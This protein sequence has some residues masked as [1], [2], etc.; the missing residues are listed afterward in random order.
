VRIT[1][2]E[3]FRERARSGFFKNFPNT[4]GGIRVSYLRTVF[5]PVEAVCSSAVCIAEVACAL[6]RSVRERII[7]RGYADYARQAFPGDSS[8]GIVQLIS[9]SEDILRAMETV[10]A[11]LPSTSFL[12]AGDAIH[13]ASAQDEGFTEIWSNDRHILKA[14]PHFGLAGRS[15]Q[16]L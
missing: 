15:V 5:T 13:L 16:K 14:A 11:R 6:R 1:L 4:N 2:A 7:T 10:T 3:V 9:L 8:R 12:R